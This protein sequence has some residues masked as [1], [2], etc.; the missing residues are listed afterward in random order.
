[1]PVDSTTGHSILSFMDRFSGYNQILMALEDME[2]TFFFLS[3]SGV[4]IAT[5]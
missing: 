4:L 1:M 5:K 3:L 2:K